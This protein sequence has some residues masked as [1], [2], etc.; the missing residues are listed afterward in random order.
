MWSRIK[1]A[2]RIIEATADYITDI[3]RII[4]VPILMTIIL[5]F[6]LLW[7]SYSG[8]YLFSA[9]TTVWNPKLPWGEI[10]WD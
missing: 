8:A 4:I 10:K 3:K 1:L 7:W 6:Y 2:S 9:G 5:L